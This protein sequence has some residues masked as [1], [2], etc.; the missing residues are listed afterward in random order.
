MTEEEIKTYN[1]IAALEAENERLN[2]VVDNIE[3]DVINVI[4]QFWCWYNSGSYKRDFRKM[5]EGEKYARDFIKDLIK[6]LSEA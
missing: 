6:E 2:L 5:A 4:R 3:T 1:K